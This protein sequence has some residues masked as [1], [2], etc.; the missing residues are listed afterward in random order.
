M[1]FV[2]ACCGGVGLSAI[3]IASAL[4]A[5]VVA[6]DIA[7]SIPALTGMDRFEGAG[8]TVIDRF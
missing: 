6:I 5:N 8:V 3:V 7:E 1:P 2:C 4:G